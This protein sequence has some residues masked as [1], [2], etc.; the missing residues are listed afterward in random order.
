M[1]RVCDEILIGALTHE[2]EELE[3]EG[4]SNS[5]SLLGY[6]K[7]SRRLDTLATSTFDNFM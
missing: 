3:G 2:I 5:R 4:S 7:S 6:I 1:L